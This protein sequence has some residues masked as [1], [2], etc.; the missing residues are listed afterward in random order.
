MNTTTNELTAREMVANLRKAMREL[1]AEWH[2]CDNDT[3]RAAVQNEIDATK[4][5]IRN[6][7]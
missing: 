4:L 7:S 1:Y 5:A 3:A 2:K 6:L